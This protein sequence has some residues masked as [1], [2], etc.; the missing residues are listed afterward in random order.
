MYSPKNIPGV[1]WCYKA[2]NAV[3]L[4]SGWSFKLLPNAISHGRILDKCLRQ[5]HVAL[6]YIKQQ[7]I[8]VEDR[9]D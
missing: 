7:I 1:M 3:N 9:H 4:I 6:F 5:V 8:L 2:S